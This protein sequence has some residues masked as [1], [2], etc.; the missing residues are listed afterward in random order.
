M[1][2]PLHYITILVSFPRAE[3]LPFLLC[4]AFTLLM[5]YTVTVPAKLTLC[6]NFSGMQLQKEKHRYE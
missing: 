2:I 6:D 1:Q 5:G 3:S 4:I